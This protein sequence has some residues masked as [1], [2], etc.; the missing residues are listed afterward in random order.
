MTISHKQISSISKGSSVN[1]VTALGWR[2]HGREFSLCSHAQTAGVHPASY[3]M[4]TKNSFAAQGK[5]A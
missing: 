1:E 5:T 2:I 4:S 3:P